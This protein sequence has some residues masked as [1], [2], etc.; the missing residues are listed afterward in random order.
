MARQRRTSQVLETARQRLAGLKTI[1]PDP[2]FGAGLTVAG[3]EQEITAFSGSLD[4]YNGKLAELD[5]LL[6]ALEDQE[7]NLREKNRRMLSVT[8]AKFGPDSSQFELAGGKRQSERK[9]PTRKGPP[10]T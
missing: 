9:R 8:E 3:Y 6:N 2:D 4:T 10:K 7:R 5:D 1:T